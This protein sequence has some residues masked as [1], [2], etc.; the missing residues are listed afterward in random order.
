MCNVKLFVL[1]EIKINFFV[2]VFDI[3]AV[4]ICPCYEGVLTH[5]LFFLPQVSSESS[6][7]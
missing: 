1:R 6:F 2:V 7:V 5:T 3:N 4:I